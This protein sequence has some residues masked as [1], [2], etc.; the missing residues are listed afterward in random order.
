MTCIVGLVDECKVYIGAD[1]AGVAGWQLTIRK[2]QKV[3][4]N[5][6]FL[7]GFT[8]SF[9]MGQLLRYSLTLPACED[10]NG[11]ERYMATTFVNAVRECLKA[12][13]YAAKNSERE[14]GGNFLVGYKGRLF[15]IEADY[16][17]GES[18]AGYD[19]VGCGS[20]VAKGSLFATPKY[21]PVAR[22]KTALEAAEQWNNGVR[23]PFV[24]EVLE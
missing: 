3:F 11:I 19:A 7:I 16:Q 20:D 14:E 8:S 18:L 6:D 2:D 9:R 15:S 24:V 23:G 13:G 5:G 10:A 12:G 21:G 1:S 17:V 4:R 22:V